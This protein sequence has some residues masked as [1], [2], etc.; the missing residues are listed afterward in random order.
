M[1]HDPPDRDG[2]GRAQDRARHVRPRRH[3]FGLAPEGYEYS[4]HRDR[5]RAEREGGL[6]ADQG[7]GPGLA[8]L[9]GGHDAFQCW[10]KSVPHQRAVRHGVPMGAVARRHGSCDPPPMGAAEI[11][12]VAASVSLLSGWRLYLCIF[13]TGVAMH[14]GWIAL[15]AHLHQLDILA[16]PRVIGVAGAAALAEFLADKVMWID[17]ALGHGTH[18]DPA[19][20]R[21]IARARHYRSRRS[22]MAGHRADPG[23]RR[24]AADAQ[25]QGRHARRGQ[26]SAPNR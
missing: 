17:S 13:A 4:A 21:G 19:D 20:R 6:A 1:A 10:L 12:G 16:N 2:A 22:E 14:S 15:P 11:L 3:S 18:A 25:R 24:L 7:L 23:R 9:S 5:D 8:G 26:S